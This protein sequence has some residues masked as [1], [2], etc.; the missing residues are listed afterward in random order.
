MEYINGALGATILGL[1]VLGFVIRDTPR[2][3]SWLIPYILL[4]VS[5]VISPQILGGY[6]AENI[7]Q[8]I[9]AAGMAVYG[10]QLIKQA[11]NAFKEKDDTHE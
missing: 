8:A 1:Y 7:V 3:P 4:V 5:C 6:N 11:R 2:I 10:D 9:I